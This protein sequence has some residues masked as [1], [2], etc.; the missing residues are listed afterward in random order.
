M[1][2]VKIVIAIMMTMMICIMTEALDWGGVGWGPQG[3]AH[4]SLAPPSSLDY[5]KHHDHLCDNH[6]VFMKTKSQFIKLHI[7][8]TIYGIIIKSSN[9]IQYLFINQIVSCLNIL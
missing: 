6:V 7:N 2:S 8:P 5:T 4:K 1:I 9:S 3:N